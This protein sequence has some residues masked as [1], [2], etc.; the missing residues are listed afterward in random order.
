MVDNTQRNIV[1]FLVLILLVIGTIFVVSVGNT[2]F[3]PGGRG[4]EAARGSS[5][6]SCLPW[7]SLRYGGC[8]SPVECTPPPSGMVS[9]WPGDGNAQDIQDGNDGTLLGD[10]GWVGGKVGNAFQFNG[11]D[12]YVQ[13]LDSNNL[14]VDSIT[15][16][17][18]MKRQ[19]PASGWEGLISKGRPFIEGWSMTMDA[20]GNLLCTITRE[21]G[22]EVMQIR[23]QDY[24]GFGVPFDVWTHVAC[25]YDKQTGEGG[26]YIDGVGHYVS[27]GP[28]VPIRHNEDEL[29]IGSH[30][31]DSES[32]FFSGLIDEVEIFDRA[33]SQSEIQIIFDAGSDG[34]C[35]DDVIDCGD[36][37]LQVGGECGDVNEYS[38]GVL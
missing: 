19:D 11:V 34:K 31:E 5:V 28:N 26:L 29:W 37:I 32:G 7:E 12:S 17:F 2:F 18:W 35:K 16:D 25:T 10:L 15:I 30:M 23:S 4:L 27:A 20:D 21:L 1:I 9:W 3:S 6:K 22:S 36:G 8:D 38:G 14:D 13:V 24:L 33:L